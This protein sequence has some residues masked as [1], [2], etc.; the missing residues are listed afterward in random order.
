M[1]PHEPSRSWRSMIQRSAVRSASRR[2]D[3]T[4]WRSYRCAAWS[5]TTNTRP[6]TSDGTGAGLPVRSSS[7]PNG[8]EARGCRA[9]TTE[10]ATIVCRAQQPNW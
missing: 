1:P 3:C 7:I 8:T 2:S 10:S 5:S 4:G 6:Q 9:V